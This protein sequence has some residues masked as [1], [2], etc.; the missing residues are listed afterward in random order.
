MP[1][2]RRRKTAPEKEIA[3]KERTCRGEKENTT[4]HKAPILGLACTRKG[5]PPSRERAR[6][7]VCICRPFLT[8]EALTL[9]TQILNTC[10]P[11][12]SQPLEGLCGIQAGCHLF[13]EHILHMCI[14]VRMGMCAC[15]F[16][17]PKTKFACLNI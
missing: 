11:Y 3:R 10:C 7:H 4:R 2:L 15:I 9:D 6:A 8:L 16:Y 13:V 5:A 12:T 1:L 14:C 17:V